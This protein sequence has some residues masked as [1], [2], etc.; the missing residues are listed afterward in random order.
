MCHL[1][2]YFGEDHGGDHGSPFPI[3]GQVRGV[4]GGWEQLSVAERDE[5]QLKDRVVGRPHFSFLLW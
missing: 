4:A 1:Q 5:L 3:V 2:T